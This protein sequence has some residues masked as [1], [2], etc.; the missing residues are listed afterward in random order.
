MTLICP[1][2]AQPGRRNHHHAQQSQFHQL[3]SFGNNPHLPSHTKEYIILDLLASENV[4][5]LKGTLQ[6]VSVNLQVK[7]GYENP[8]CLLSCNPHVGTSGHTGHTHTHTN[9]AQGRVR[10]TTKPVGGHWATPK[11]IRAASTI[12]MQCNLLVC[13]THS[14]VTTCGTMRAIMIGLVL[15][16]Q[17][18]I[19]RNRFKHLLSSTASP[20]GYPYSSNRVLPFLLFSILEISQLN[21][22]AP[23]QT[24]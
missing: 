1:I 7:A 9:T 3:I 5:I 2:T 10:V 14:V 22:F 19:L 23:V 21:P 17:C 12:C 18:N 4:L 8:Y 6:G 15:T 16:V 20:G 24:S 11:H 13:S